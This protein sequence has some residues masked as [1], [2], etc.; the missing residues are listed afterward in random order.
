MYSIGMTYLLKPGCYADY[1][2]AHD[3]LWL[4]IAAGMAV[5][6]V[7][8]II[9]RYGDRLFLH[10]NAPTREDWLRSREGPELERW[11]EYM[12]NYL[13]ADEAGQIIFEDMEVAFVFGVFK[14]E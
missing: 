1:K 12:L 7:S 10:A 11:T 4:E 2:K 5:N 14:E 3:E 8:M 13:V 9:Y 6:H